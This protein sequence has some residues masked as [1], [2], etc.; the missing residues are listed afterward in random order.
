[1]QFEIENKFAAQVANAI[2]NSKLA[3]TIGMD[4]SI[5]DQI[6]MALAD[7]WD[8][9]IKAGMTTDYIQ[10]IANRHVENGLPRA[11][12]SNVTPMRR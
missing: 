5:S 2:G 10:A 4:Q 12:P 7:L 11:L 1:M 3:N 6:E 9:G 8:E